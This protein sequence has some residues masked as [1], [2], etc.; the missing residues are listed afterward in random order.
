M[1]ANFDEV[2]ERDGKC[3][4]TSLYLDPMLITPSHLSQASDFLGMCEYFP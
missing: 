1:N 4:Q 3:N 2:E